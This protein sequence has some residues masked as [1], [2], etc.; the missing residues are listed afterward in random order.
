MYCCDPIVHLWNSTRIIAG[1]V[2]SK[3][4]NLLT[5]TCSVCK[6]QPARMLKFKTSVVLLDFGKLCILG[7]IAS[8]LK[9]WGLISFSH[10]QD[11]NVG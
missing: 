5:S 8:D 1:E 9:V 4:Q 6:S 3:R 7:G 11:K 2:E 10:L